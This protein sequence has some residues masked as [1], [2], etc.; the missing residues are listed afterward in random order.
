MIQM[1]LPMGFKPG[2]IARELG[3]SAGT[4]SRELKRNGWVRPKLPRDV[5]R[6]AIAGGYRADVAQ[7]RATACTLKPHALRKVRPGTAL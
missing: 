2:Q 7:R 6:P 1:Q 3:R 5:G 4:L